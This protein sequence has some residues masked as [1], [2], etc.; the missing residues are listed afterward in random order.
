MSPRSTVPVSATLA[1]MEWHLQCPDGRRLTLAA[2]VDM[3]VGAAGNAQL[4]LPALPDR[5]ALLQRR[6]DDV[7]MQVLATDTQVGVNGRPVQ[8]LSRLRAGDRVCFGSS[9]IDLVAAGRGVPG[10]D[11][12]ADF[13]LRVR[14]GARSGNVHRGPVLHLDDHGEVVSAAAGVVGLILVEGSVRLDPNGSAIRLNGTPL[15]ETVT[16][17]DGDQLQIGQRRYIV[18][19]LAA[20]PPEQ[21]TQRLEVDDIPLVADVAS[22]RPAAQ[23]AGGLWG[24]IVLAAVIAGAV[25]ILLYFNNA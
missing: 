10:T 4:K 14:N 21:A 20:P 13:F 15:K 6:G 3:L 23:Q 9:C 1:A 24:L 5:C 22:A 19:T 17:V 8:H 12:V 7:W 16:V 2:D 11:T 25:A 18:E